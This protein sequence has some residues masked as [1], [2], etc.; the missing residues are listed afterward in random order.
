[1][2][3][4]RRNAVSRMDSKG[5]LVDALVRR[6]EFA[7]T[8]GFAVGPGEVLGVLGPNGSGK[9]T[10]LSALAGLLPLTDGR[11]ELAG[12]VIDD[13]GTGAFVEAAGRPIGFVFQDYRLFPHLN[14]RDNVAF[15]PRARGLG[16]VAAR[17]IAETWLERLGLRELADRKPAQ[18]SGGQAQRV[19][20]ARA[21]AGDPAMLLLDEPL[22]ALDAKTRLDVQTEL[23]QHL[24]EFGGPCLLVTH[25][26]L[27]ALVLVDRLLVLEN[28]RIVQE[29]SPAYVARRPA[30]DYVAKLV[31][32]NL[33]SGHAEGPQ[34]AI[35]GG[36]RLVIPDHDDHGEVLVAMRPSSVVVSTHHPE[37]SSA[38]NSWPATV[39]GLTL[40]ADRVR[41]DMDGRPP[42][43][44]DVTPA[45]IA[46]LDLHSGSEVWLTVKATDLEI[47][48]PAATRPEP[49]DE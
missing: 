47:Y 21:L 6:G 13:A 12:Q 49:G 7:L 42:A 38:R 48:R 36:G 9:S 43:L 27:E 30:T 1:V 40:L 5:L 25:D 17:S 34:V 20:L 22:A 32:L 28:G 8:V 18:L 45:A 19:A 26:P 44:V 2:A 29:G 4:Q 15:S 11:L 41:L 31:G 14:V 33:Y 24:A 23:N 16:R 35:S 10:L 39:A 46:D 37:P 3:T